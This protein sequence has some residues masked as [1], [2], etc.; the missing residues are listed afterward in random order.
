MQT[1]SDQINAN[2]PIVPTGTEAN[3]PTVNVQLTGSGPWGGRYEELEQ[4][5]VETN[6]VTDPI[7]ASQVGW[8]P[9]LAVPQSLSDLLADASLNVSAMVL[10]VDAIAFGPVPVKLALI[11][12]WLVIVYVGKMYASQNRA[13]AR[14]ANYRRLLSGIGVGLGIVMLMARLADPFV[15]PMV[16]R[17]TPIDMPYYQEQYRP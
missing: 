7:R 17:Y 8:V 14:T 5:T 13:L 4:V 6:R 9:R 3:T 15:A 2:G 16:D 12:G 1:P 10:T 11:G